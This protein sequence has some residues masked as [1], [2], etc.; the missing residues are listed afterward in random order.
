MAEKALTPPKGTEASEEETS[1]GGGII[2]SF[3][4]HPFLWG[5]G[6]GAV[7]AGGAAV[8]VYSGLPLIGKLAL[9]FLL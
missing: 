9:A 6:A 4:K 2:G 5:L 1:S 8:A 7:F 3:K